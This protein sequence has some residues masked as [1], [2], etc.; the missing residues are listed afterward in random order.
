MRVNYRDVED[1]LGHIDGRF[2][3][4][5]IHLLGRSDGEDEADESFFTIEYYPVWEHPKVAEAI[6]AGA[7]WRFVME[8][9]RGQ[10]TIYPLGI[11]EV[12][13]SARPDCIDV[14][15]TQNDPHL[16]SY[17]EKATLF[18]AGAFPFDL[19]L[20]VVREIAHEIGRPATVSDVMRYLSPGPIE[21]WGARGSFALGHFPTTLFHA[22][23]RVL[24]KHGIPTFAPHEPQEKP[25]P[26]LFAL[27]GDYIIADDFE[28]DMPEF[29]HRPE[30]V[31]S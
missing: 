18:C 24:A 17:E 21:R 6:K 26:V 25:L 23:R 28:V 11:R 8:P 27:G 19:W 20:P 4:A 30:W 12:R 31:E 22:A 13:L 5:R 7:S 14:W 10:M 1:R 3:E 15:F 16:W 9:D 2:V 29:E